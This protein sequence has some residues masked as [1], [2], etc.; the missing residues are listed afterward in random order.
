MG[1]PVDDTA[2]IRRQPSITAD[3]I[4]GEVVRE[5]G[6]PLLARLSIGTSGLWD[7]WYLVLV[8]KDDGETELGWS[9]VD[10]VYTS[11]RYGDACKLPIS[12]QEEVLLDPEQ[13]QL[14]E[15]W[16]PTLEGHVGDADPLF[17]QSI[18]EELRLP[19]PFDVMPADDR[20]TRISNQG[21]GLNRFAFLNSDFYDG[22][23]H[24]HSGLDF[25]STE[26]VDSIGQECA[27]GDA[28]Y[29]NGECFRIRAV[30]DGLVY[31]VSDPLS[32]GTGRR[33]SLRCT[34]PDGSLSNLYVVYN[35]LRDRVSDTEFSGG[36]WVSA[37]DILGGL[38]VFPY[39]TTTGVTPPHLH[40]E[41]FYHRGPDFS[42]ETSSTI[43]LNPLLF[44]SH[45]LVQLIS[46][47]K[48]GYYYPT[49]SYTDTGEEKRY[50]WDDYDTD[51]P[52]DIYA[53]RLAYVRNDPESPEDY[54][55]GIDPVH[56][57]TFACLG[58]TFP[59]VSDPIN[60][61]FREEHYPGIQHL[62]SVPQPETPGQVIR[63]W[64]DL[65]IRLQ[66]GQ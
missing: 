37:G 21:Y 24:I 23:N 63:S 34:A 39:V 62:G 9:R 14:L 40:L 2:N 16:G 8:V 66:Q 59:P 28:V 13:R 17:E 31:A 33:L 45:M 64:S 53:L 30:C 44:F 15:L 65:V 22:T 58:D 49:G 19:A 7:D 27:A 50:E 54:D 41:V 12:D 1:F 4:P 25:S 43:R 57:G 61:W 3:L 36:E 26:A 32:T 29:P 55:L 6:R 11:P 5:E 20:A 56:N 42:P 48:M 46:D 52:G 35:H 18:H 10:V 47:S 38:R 60:V 51:D